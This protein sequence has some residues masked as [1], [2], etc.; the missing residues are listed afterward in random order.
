MNMVNWSVQRGLGGGE[1]GR[2]SVIQAPALDT[3]KR[4][5]AANPGE[6]GLAPVVPQFNKLFG[7]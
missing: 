3:G 5:L 2:G 7:R 6:R 4:S 1:Q